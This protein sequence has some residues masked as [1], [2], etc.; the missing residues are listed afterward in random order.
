LTFEHP[1][2]LSFALL[3]GQTGPVNIGFEAFEML[4]P[5]GFVLG[6]FPLD[7]RPKSLLRGES[8]SGVIFGQVVG[9]DTSEYA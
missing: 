2:D 9:E 5:P 6:P 8:G 3:R 1:T 7:E 4:I